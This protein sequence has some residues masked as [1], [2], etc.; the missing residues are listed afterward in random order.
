VPDGKPRQGRRPNTRLTQTV[1]VRPYAG[2]RF[3]AWVKDGE[4]SPAGELQAAAL[5]A[6][7]RALSFQEG[8]LK[9][10]QD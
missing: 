10:T 2:Y 4:L 7:G 8:E 3:S 9:P 6:K 1:K 5:G